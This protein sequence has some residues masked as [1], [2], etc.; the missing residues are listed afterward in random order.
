M[1]YF[2]GRVMTF[3]ETNYK[4][5]HCVLYAVLQLEQP[6]LKITCG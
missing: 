2:N 6:L 5:R 3:E 1:H 4:D